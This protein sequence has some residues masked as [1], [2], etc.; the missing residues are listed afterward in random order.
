MSV[1]HRLC[2]NNISLQMQ[3]VV[4]ERPAFRLSTVPYLPRLR[5]LIWGDYN[6]AE[7]C[8]LLRSFNAL[9]TLVL[10]GSPLQN[11]VVLDLA[12]LRALEQ[13]HIINFAPQSIAACKGCK[14]HVSWDDDALV[15]YADLRGFTKWLQSNLWTSLTLP[16]GSLKLTYRDILLEDH[17]MAIE[18]LVNQKHPLEFI[19]LAI[20]EF[21]RE[22]EPIQITKQW[23]QG[24]LTT[25]V[26]SITTFTTCNLAFL[27]DWP[28]WTHLSIYSQGGIQMEAESMQGTFQGLQHCSIVGDSFRCTFMKQLSAGS[29]HIG[30]SLHA[31]AIGHHTIK[32]SCCEWYH[33]R[34]RPYRFSALLGSAEAA[35]V[36][37]LMFCGCHGCLPCLRRDGFVSEDIKIQHDPNHKFFSPSFCHGAGNGSRR[38]WRHHEQSKEQK[39]VEPVI[40]ESRL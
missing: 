40:S 32:R 2:A 39:I 35:G 27:Y 11:N 12:H 8:P 6:I 18:K 34:G 4:T 22:L 28:S 1:T 19:S 7:L 9:Q 14:L 26:L 5:H 17:M 16:L 25:K 21:G 10:S 20:R 3:V 24:L 37:S 29:C 36:N 31:S 15:A 33:S 13:L 23:W 38:R 30:S